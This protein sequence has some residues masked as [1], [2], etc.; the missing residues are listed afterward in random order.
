MMLILIIWQESFHLGR[1]NMHQIS[2]NM[3]TTSNKIRTS[4]IERFFVR[5]FGSLQKGRLDESTIKRIQFSV[6]EISY[7]HL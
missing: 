1:L 5:S 2:Q 3:S 4:A 6:S 7:S